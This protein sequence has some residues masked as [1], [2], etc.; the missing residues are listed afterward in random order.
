MS[1]QF[2]TLLLLLLHL[3]GCPDRSLVSSEVMSNVTQCHVPQTVTN[4]IPL[5]LTYYISFYQKGK[6]RRRNGTYSH[7]DLWTVF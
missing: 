6:G 7:I 2:S 3:L 5:T 4:D 1:V